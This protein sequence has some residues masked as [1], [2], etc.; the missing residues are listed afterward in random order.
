MKNLLCFWF[1]AQ[2]DDATSLSW[3]VCVCVCVCVCQKQVLLQ[4]GM[5]SSVEQMASSVGSFSF[6]PSSSRSRFLVHSLSSPSCTITS[7]LVQL[8]F[9]PSST[10][11][12]TSMFPTF[13]SH[14]SP[15]YTFPHLVSSRASHT[16]SDS[17]K[18][19]CFFPP[20]RHVWLMSDKSR[21]STI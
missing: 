10:F 14:P 11:T 20:G 12:T 15:R 13:Y 16:R 6:T 21:C 9:L 5:T 1:K 19:P 4:P 2:K 3:C 18:R 8:C 7:L 17:C